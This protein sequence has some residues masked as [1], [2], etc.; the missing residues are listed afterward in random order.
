MSNPEF[1]SVSDRHGGG[2]TMT[3]TVPVRLTEP[4]MVDL[5]A[6]WL[7]E[8]IDRMRSSQG[9]V[10]LVD[11]L[12][13]LLQQGMA[14]VGDVIRDAERGDQ[15]ADL[16]LWRYYGSLINN[17]RRPTVLLE[18]F[19]VRATERGGPVKR[20]GRPKWNNLTR[21][22]GA[23]ALM[24]TICLNF[25]LQLSRGREPALHSDP[26]PCACSVLSLALKRHRIHL[27][28]ENLVNMLPRLKLYVGRYLI[29]VLESAPPLTPLLLC[30]TSAPDRPS[31]DLG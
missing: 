29:S 28:E 16:A 19:V 25:G 9:Q 14:D 11:V 3:T 1:H 21:D 30:M 6:G 5:A 18:A 10:M 24:F 23:A 15:L 22:V 17:H 20:S 4:E 2:C 26:P 8:I 27:S 31:I 7:G 13:G 12:T